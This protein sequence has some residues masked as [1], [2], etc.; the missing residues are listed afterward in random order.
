MPTVKQEKKRRKNHIMHGSSYLKHVITERKVRQ[1]IPAEGH[2][3][4]DRKDSRWKAVRRL[5]GCRKVAPSRIV[6]PRKTWSTTFSW[7]KILRLQFHKKKWNFSK[8]T[9][10]KRQFKRGPAQ[11]TKNKTQKKSLLFKKATPRSS[12]NSKIRLNTSNVTFQPLHMTGCYFILFLAKR[13]LY[14]FFLFF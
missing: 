5:G 7:G 13:E 9:F 1:F 4:F 14:P 8:V 12:M 2:H 6:G 3:C 11:H 10:Q